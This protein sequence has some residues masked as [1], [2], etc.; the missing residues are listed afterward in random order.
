MLFQLKKSYT[1]ASREAGWLSESAN[2]KPIKDA[3]LRRLE[4]LK[5]ERAFVKFMRR[6]SKTEIEGDKSYFF[7]Y[8]RP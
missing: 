2:G 6:V 4:P 5:I 8:P 1:Y 7:T 3:F